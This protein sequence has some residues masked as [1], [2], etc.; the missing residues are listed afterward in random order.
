MEDYTSIYGV[1]QPGAPSAPI[2]G[3]VSV[4]RWGR[5]LF[6]RC[7]LSRQPSPRASTI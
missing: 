5:T 1:L 2:C 4:R 7:V 3:P 6:R